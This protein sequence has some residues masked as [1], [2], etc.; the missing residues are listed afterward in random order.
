V[1]EVS[2]SSTS[3]AARVPTE[4]YDGASETNASSQSSALIRSTP[5][6][7]LKRSF[8]SS[9]RAIVGLPIGSDVD[10]VSGSRSPATWSRARRRCT[11]ATS[12]KLPERISHTYRP[13]PSRQCRVST[14][15]GCLTTTLFF[16]DLHHGRC[17]SEEG[18]G[19]AHI[20]LR[21]RPMGKF[22]HA[23]P[24]AC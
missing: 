21:Q 9:S 15:A 23:Q 6:S 17:W 2:T 5:P 8:L 19:P 16:A 3:P 10:D 20:A 18:S 12:S 4:R 1:P 24:G 13:Y 7:S 14:S 11:T 22:P